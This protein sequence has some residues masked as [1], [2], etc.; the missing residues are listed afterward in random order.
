[1]YYSIFIF[2]IDILHYFGCS[3]TEIYYNYVSNKF[4]K[5]HNWNLMKNNSK[6]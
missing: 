6:N 2:K 5:F 3:S 4:G 1:M